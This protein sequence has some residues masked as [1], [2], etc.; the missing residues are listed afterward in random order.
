[1][2]SLTSMAGKL[3]FGFMAEGLSL[4][5][6]FAG[7]LILTILSFG[8]LLAASGY[9]SLLAPVSCSGWPLAECCPYGV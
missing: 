3:G 8:I 1:V 9:I 5:W 7:A 2:L 4:K 6:L